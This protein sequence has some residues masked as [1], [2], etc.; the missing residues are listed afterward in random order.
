MITFRVFLGIE[1]WTFTPLCTTPSVTY[2]L[3]ATNPSSKTAPNFAN[4]SPTSKWRTRSLKVW[5]DNFTKNRKPGLLELRAK[6]RELNLY[7]VGKAAIKTFKIQILVW[8]SG[9]CF[10]EPCLFYVTPIRALSNSTNIILS[11]CFC[12]QVNLSKVFDDFC[13]V[14]ASRQIALHFLGPP[15]SS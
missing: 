10:T 11:I 4:R 9:P 8:E 13:S 6:C 7:V 14:K 12:K 1:Q 5:R 15:Q 2:F 3:T